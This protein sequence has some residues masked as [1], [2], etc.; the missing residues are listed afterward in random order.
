MKKSQ[1]GEKSGIHKVFL[2][3]GELCGMLSSPNGKNFQALC[4]H[5]VPAYAKA[6]GA[7]WSVTFRA[8][9]VIEDPLSLKDKWTEFTEIGEGC[10]IGTRKSSPF[11]HT[12]L[13]K[14]LITMMHQFGTP[15]KTTVYGKTFDNKGRKVL[16]LSY[17]GG[18]TYTYSGKTTSPGQPFGKETL[19]FLR[20]EL[21]FGESVSVEDVWAH[22]VYYPTPDCQLGWHQD[23][24]NGLNP[25]A[26]ISLTL[27]EDPEL[28]VRP[29]Y[30]RLLSDKK[31]NK[32][33][34]IKKVL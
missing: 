16:E 29:F 1:R 8:R 21:L 14:E 32:K 34:K 28:G 18:Q 25:H 6:R 12:N 24:E 17:E 23:N 2:N 22:M 4:Q 20:A 19:A 11:V 3:H 7:R 10:Y 5:C 30:V 31:K 26:I 13:S 27:L 15:D 9:G 33:K